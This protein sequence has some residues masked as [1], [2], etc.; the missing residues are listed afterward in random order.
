M[1]RFLAKIAIFMVPFVVLAISF[2]AWDP[3]KVVFAYESFDSH[4]PVA[5]NVDYLAT[6]TYLRNRKTVGYDSF[7]FGNSR[8]LG[9]RTNAWQRCIDDGVPFRYSADAESVYGVW[10]K[11]KMIDSLHAP[12]RNA[13]LLMDA[14]FLAAA[15]NPDQHLYFKHPAV[16]GVS[17]LK[18]YSVFM[19]AYVSDVFFVKYFDYRM[20]GDTRAYMEGV[21]NED[22]MRIDPVTN[23][24]YLDG[25]DS[26]MA[27]D[28]DEYYE[29]LTGSFER[30]RES[31]GVFDGSAIQKR[32]RAMLEEIHSILVSRGTAYQIIIGP[33]YHQIPLDREDLATLRGIF[34]AAE[35]H[36]YSGVNEITSDMRNYY[37]PRHFTPA[38][39]KKIID[40]I[41]GH[42]VQETP[43]G[44]NPAF[45]NL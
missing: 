28:S 39:G 1:K 18:F 41:C 40:D 7:I 16:S 44:P 33:G 5:L 36:D 32:Q 21:I 9:F 11:L 37:E 24:L 2:V 13:M 22:P 31:Q 25:R 26:L 14:Q 15:D 17:W 20:F 3:F 43:D 38:A 4:N 19:T 34:G 45:R 8:T 42:A 10:A 27:Q 30:Y 29:A 6:E 23:D 12:I 35:V